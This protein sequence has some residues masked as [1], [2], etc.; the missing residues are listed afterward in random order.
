MK[1]LE[2]IRDYIR[3]SGVAPIGRRYFIMNAFDGTTTILGI[4]IGA[5]AAEITNQFWVI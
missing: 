2:K 1:F 3:I 4:V 5:Y